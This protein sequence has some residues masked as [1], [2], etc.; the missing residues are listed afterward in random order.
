MVNLLIY[1]W[2]TEK[3]S[4]LDWDSNHRSLHCRS[5][6]S[7]WSKVTTTLFLCWRST[8]E[9]IVSVFQVSTLNQL[10]TLWNNPD[11]FKVLIGKN[12]IIVFQMCIDTIFLCFCEDSE[13][14]DGITKPYYMSRNLMVSEDKCHPGSCI[15]VPTQS[16]ITWAGTSWWVKM[17]VTSLFI[18]TSDVFIR[19][20]L[21]YIILWTVANKIH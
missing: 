9:R 17:G 15:N 13:R 5:S 20:W 4:C 19:I 7:E 3:S 11:R 14:N 8:A 12:V 16:H 18:V 1:I 21:I 10:I 6:L 2:N